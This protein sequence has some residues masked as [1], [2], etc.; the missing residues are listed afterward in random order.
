MFRPWIQGRRV[1]GALRKPVMVLPEVKYARLPSAREAMVPS[2]CSKNHGATLPAER[3]YVTVLDSGEALHQRL[4][5][6]LQHKDTQG[7]SE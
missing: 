2:M 6:L 1:F 5:G 3:T 7:H 4:A